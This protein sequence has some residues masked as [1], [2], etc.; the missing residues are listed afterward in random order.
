MLSLRVSTCRTLLTGAFS[1]AGGAALAS[2]RGYVAPPVLAALGAF[3]ENFGHVRVPLAF[4]VPDAE[5]WPAEARRLKL[6]QRVH[7]LRKKKKGGTLPQDDVAQL[8]ALG[9]VWDLKGWKWQ[10]VLQALQAYKQVHGDLEVPCTQLFVV[11]SE[12]PWPEE[13]WGMQLGAMV[14]RIRRTDEYVKDYPERRAQLDALGFA[15]DAVSERRWEEVRTA[16]L[17]YKEVHGDLEVPTRFLVPSEAQWPEKAWGMPL[18]RRVQGIRSQNV[19]MLEDH[20]ERRA[21]LGALGFRWGSRQA[22]GVRGGRAHT[23]T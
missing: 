6:G 5:G 16:L 3:G 2:A 4:V 21:E 13:A 18:G 14:G 7:T 12:A 8:D 10:R 1:G 23:H 15:W 9:F 22:L 20:P 19:Y 11:P 17:V